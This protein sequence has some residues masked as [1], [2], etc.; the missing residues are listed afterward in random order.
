MGG[1][2]LD[3]EGSAPV[4]LPFQTVASRCRE[5]PVPS[6]SRCCCLPALMFAQLILPFLMALM[7]ALDGPRVA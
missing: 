2:A 4:C 3:S 1:R 5:N 6:F 7:I